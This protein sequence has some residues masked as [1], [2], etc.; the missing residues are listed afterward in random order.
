[1]LAGTPTTVGTYTFTIRG[2]DANGC[3]AQHSYTMPV[4]TPVPTLPQAFM[5]MLAVGLAG[6][7]YFRLRR[8]A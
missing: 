4:T 5:I 6:A 8:R 1:V 7:G 3:F 2:T